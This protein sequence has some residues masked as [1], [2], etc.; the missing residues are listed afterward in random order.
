MLF[1]S[2]TATRDIER[3][4]EVVFVDAKAACGDRQR[5]LRGQRSR[6]NIAFVVA[7]TIGG[8]WRFRFVCTDLHQRCAPCLGEVLGGVTQP[9]SGGRAC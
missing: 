9:F 3:V 4:T 7:Y 1:R 5:V 8:E 2:F 6:V